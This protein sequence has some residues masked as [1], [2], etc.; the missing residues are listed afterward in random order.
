MH[1]RLCSA[2][3]L[4]LRPLPTA[5]VRAPSHDAING[6]RTLSCWLPL[7]STN[8]TCGA[9]DHRIQLA[10]H[11]HICISVHKQAVLTENWRPWQLGCRNTAPTSR[12]SSLAYTR[13]PGRSLKRDSDACQSFPHASLLSIPTTSHPL[14]A[15]ISVVTP[16]TRPKLFSERLAGP[17]STRSLD[18]W[19][20]R[21]SSGR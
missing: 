18:V 3:A 10:L 17:S 19:A 1:R 21:A 13:E 14:A 6:S 4:R 8:T 2:Q 15:I 9:C 5:R 16:Y 7:T 11:C 20:R 12:P